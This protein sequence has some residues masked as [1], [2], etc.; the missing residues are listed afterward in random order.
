MTEETRLRPKTKS[1]FLTNHQGESVKNKNKRKH[2]N[3]SS[4]R[5]GLQATDKQFREYELMF[6]TFSAD[7]IAVVDNTYRYR[8]VNDA[9]LKYYKASKKQIIGREISEVLGQ[10]VFEE[11]VKPRLEE[12][13]RGQAT[14]FE[15]KK[16]YPA[17]NERHLQ[18]SYLPL[19]KARKVEAVIAIIRDVTDLKRSLNDLFNSREL[20]RAMTDWSGDWEYLLNE[21]NEIIYMSP[22]VSTITG[23]NEKEFK[24]NLSLIEEI[25]HAEDRQTWESHAAMHCD[26]SGVA[27][28]EF[29]IVTRDGTT[30]WISHICRSIPLGQS[31]ARHVSNRDITDYKESTK[32]ERFFANILENISMAFAVATPDRGL[33]A[34]NEAYCQL[35]GYSKEEFQER[36]IRWLEDLTPLEWQQH[37]LQMLDEAQRNRRP[38]SYEKEYIRKDGSR[39][40]IELFVEPIFE[41]D[42]LKYFQGIVTDITER[43]RAEEAI[44]ES[45]QRFKTLIEVSPDAIYVQADGLFVY[46]N[47][48]MIALLGASQPGDLLGKHFMSYVAPEYHQAIRSRIKHQRDTGESVPYMEQ[49]YVRIDGSHVHVECTA[50]PIRFEGVGAHLVFLRDITDRKK[51]EDSLRSSL[52]RLHLA[53]EAAKA[54]SWEWDLKSD[55]NVWSDEIWQV[56]GL[57]PDCQQP[58]YDLW[59]QTVRPDDREKI[60]RTVREAVANNA[61]LVI[62]YRVNNQ[63]DGAERWLWSKGRPLFDASGYVKS[64]MG[65][66]LDITERKQADQRLQQL[67]DFYETITESI[68]SGVWVS[69][70]D[71]TMTYMNRGMSVI[72]GIPPEQAIGKNILTGFGGETNGQFKEFYLRAKETLRPVCYEGVPVVTPAGRFTYQSG[73]LIPRVKGRAFDGM[74]C[75]VDDITERKSAEEELKRREQK[76][77]SLYENSIDAIFMTKDDGTVLSANAAACEMLQ[78]TEEEICKKGRDCFQIQDAALVEAIAERNQKGR[79]RGE[80]NFVRKDGS[81]FPADVSSAV[82]KDCAFGHTNVSIVRDISERRRMEQA[83]MESERMFRLIFDQSPVGVAL[84]ALDSFRYVLVNSALCKFLGYTEDELKALTAV[85][86]THPDY[87]SDT[88]EQARRLAHGEIDGIE[89]EKKYLRKDGSSFWGSVS[90]RPVKDSEGHILHKLIIVQDINERKLAEIRLRESEERYRT[91]IESCNDGAMIIRNDKISFANRKLLT[92]FA[93]DSIDEIPDRSVLSLIADEDRELV[94]EMG[95]GRQRGANVPSVYELRGVRK[96]GNIIWVEVSVTAIKD[97]REKASLVFLRDVTERKKTEEELAKYR[98][99]LEVLVDERTSALVCVQDR[100]QFL[101]SAT[102]A[103]IWSCFASSSF[104]PFTFVSDKVKDITGYEPAEF[105]QDEDFF[106]SHVHSDDL[107]NI[108]DGFSEVMQKNHCALYF[109]FLCV[110]GSYIWVYSEC[111]LITGLDGKT[112]EIIGFSLDVTESMRMTEELKEAKQAAE[113]ADKAK[114]QFLASMSHE[115]RTPLNAIIGF[116]DVLLEKFFGDLNQKQE[117]Y[118]QD[119]FGAGQHLLSLINDILD[120]S[121]IESGGTELEVSDVNIEDLL[122]HSLIMIKEKCMKHGINLNLNIPETLSGFT[123]L[124]DERKLKQIMFNLLSNAAKFTPDGGMITVDAQLRDQEI[125]VRV[126]DTGIGISPQ[127]KDKIFDKFYQ[128]SGG[129]TDKSPGTGLGLAITKSLVEMH[130]GKILIESQGI[131]KGSCFTITLPLRA[132]VQL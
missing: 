113:A 82:I 7:L 39:I 55:L 21:R 67:K 118:A 129:K 27:R 116:S 124:A 111:R 31:M 84:V 88:I 112:D 51:A 9:F 34:F 131:G 18:V 92:I 90:V 19:Y 98:G 22:S 14:Q 43:K 79:W 48:A 30:R 37:E 114:S 69:D 97:N 3:I 47:P 5:S 15:M 2:V 76:F 46:L 128:A 125:G 87:L 73:W 32:R 64:Y 52:N 115:L 8:L 38:V 11:H 4:R 10:D 44:K 45:E 56:Y 53:H 49:E 26:H 122:T 103:V 36:N 110:N 101:L 20:F 86:V 42:S 106:L 78:R 28:T 70:P 33:L 120:L 126:S 54:G 1:S 61:D 121:K 91:A 89:L 81:V 6:E 94:T 41:G 75:T 40:P 100:L 72:A 85:D 123:I 96:Q 132:C 65:I 68:I 59:L 13:F 29:R 105:T 23:Y 66:V 130:G 99:H 71:D 35:T 117:E 57:E 95:V 60:V 83:T 93:Y 107:K 24:E 62:E 109:R 127:Q 12:A 63:E 50:V 25:I 80:L 58:S 119:I 16:G 108:Y 77:R 102:P 17:L 104:A 74:I